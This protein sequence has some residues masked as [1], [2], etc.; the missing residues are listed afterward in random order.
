VKRVVC[1]ASWATA[2]EED[3]YHYSSKIH[4]GLTRWSV[5]IKMPGTKQPLYPD[6]A[7]PLLQPVNVRGVC[8]QFAEGKA[9]LPTKCEAKR[10][11]C[12]WFVFTFPRT[13]LQTG[14]VCARRLLDFGA[15]GEERA[16]LEE[17]EEEDAPSP[18]RIL[19][20]TSRARR[21]SKED[22]ECD[23]ARANVAPANDTANTV[24]Y[25]RTYFW[26]GS[27]QDRKYAPD[28]A[29]VVYK[30]GGVFVF[31]VDHQGN[32]V[33]EGCLHWP[34]R[35]ADVCSTGLC[36]GLDEERI[37]EFA[38]IVEQSEAA[39][40]GPR[41]FTGPCTFTIQWANGATA[42]IPVSVLAKVVPVQTHS[43]A[44]AMSLLGTVG[45]KN[46]ARLASSSTKS[47]EQDKEWLGKHIARVKKLQEKKEI[48]E[49]QA[50]FLLAYYKARKGTAW[51]S[52][53]TPIPS[54]PQL[55]LVPKRKRN[56]KRRKKTDM[57]EAPARKKIETSL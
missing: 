40:S 19:R 11:A 33:S 25:V 27:T 50:S 17:E 55:N 41:K 16:S 15:K 6:P 34:G 32:Q 28:M 4:Q 22:D 43:H 44:K 46:L 13:C 49:R 29:A 30:K 54:V 39:P 10:F 21:G 14:L 38:H 20:S 53:E 3:V 8:V 37:S 35:V 9:W 42:S 57:R 48:A 52:I 24:N 26:R 7:F 31:L 12:L 47:K 23:E 51:T 1:G 2:K 36:P 18:V 45:Y 5:G 56:R